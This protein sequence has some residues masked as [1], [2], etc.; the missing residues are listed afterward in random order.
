MRG[1]EDGGLRVSLGSWPWMEVLEKDQAGPLAHLVF[2]LHLCFPSMLQIL[3]LF[4]YVTPFI[5]DFLCSVHSAV[6]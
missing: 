2:T 1:W 4:P 5:P 6:N 3:K